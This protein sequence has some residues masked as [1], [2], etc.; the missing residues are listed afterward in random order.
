MNVVVDRAR[1][2][3]HARCELTAPAVYELDDEGVVSVRHG[4]LPPELESAA[5]A[6]ARACPMAALR[7]TS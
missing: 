3:G 1:C 7:V 4:D 2:E 5:T 6:G